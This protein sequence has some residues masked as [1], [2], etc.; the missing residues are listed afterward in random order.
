MYDYFEGM[1]PLPEKHDE[2]SDSEIH[3][4]EDEYEEIFNPDAF[5]HFEMIRKRT[6]FDDDG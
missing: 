3:E 2:P 4:I 1:K 5:D 6:R